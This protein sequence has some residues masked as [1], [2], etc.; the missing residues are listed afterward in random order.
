MSAIPKNM[1]FYFFEVPHDLGGGEIHVPACSIKEAKK[2]IAEYYRP[3][4]KRNVDDLIF[5]ET[6]PLSKCS[7]SLEGTDEKTLFTVWG[8]PHD[9]RY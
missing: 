5:E 6:L 2:R 9:R 7:L 3:S 4:L 8:V 1:E